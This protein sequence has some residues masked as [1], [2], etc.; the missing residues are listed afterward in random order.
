MSSPELDKCG[1]NSDRNGRVQI[2]LPRKAFRYARQ[3]GTRGNDVTSAGQ[4][5]GIIFPAAN[6]ADPA[7][8]IVI[9]HGQNH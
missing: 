3:E 4:T 5:Q 6:A 1:Y 2:H 7:L 9:L 8:Y